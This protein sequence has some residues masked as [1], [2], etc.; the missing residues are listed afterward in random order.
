MKKP[1]TLIL[2]SIL[3]FLNGCKGVNEIQRSN[4]DPNQVPENITSIPEVGLGQLKIRQSDGMNMVY[5]PTGEFMMGNNHSDTCP[6]A[7]PK[8]AVSLDA[9]WID[10]TEITNEMFTSFLNEEGNQTTNGV[11][12]F[13]PGAGHLGI[14]YG[15]IHENDGI[16]SVK[17]GFDDFPVIEVSW[18]GAAAYCSWVGGRLPTEA[19]WEYAARGPEGNTFPW[20]NAFDGEFVNYCDH[21]CQESWSDDRYDDGSM[22]WTISG[23]YPD[24]ASW[25]NA[26][27]MAGNVWEWVN[28]WWSEEYYSISPSDNPEGPINGTFRIARGGSWYDEWWR[29]DLTCRKGLSPSSARMHWIGFRCVLQAEG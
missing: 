22:Q 2:L 14:T 27:D 19:E 17:E 21:S 25:C 9:F 15:Y 10:Q 1:L 11:L 23:Q 12:W 16:F 26:L 29:M 4:N 5:V 8:H 20:G 3:I 28:D 7:S 13:E 24:G 6:F 18:Y